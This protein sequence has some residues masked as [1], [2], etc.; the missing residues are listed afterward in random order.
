MKDQILKLNKTNTS[1]RKIKLS[2]YFDIETLELVEDKEK[3]IID[4]Y[5]YQRPNT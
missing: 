5:N 1:T 3:L 4:K 2:N